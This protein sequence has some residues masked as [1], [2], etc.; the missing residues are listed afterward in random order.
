MK[1]T[2]TGISPERKKGQKWGLARNLKMFPD[3]RIA[4]P[5]EF[6]GEGGKKA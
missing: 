3:K 1:E 4:R 2:Q 5:A 6:G